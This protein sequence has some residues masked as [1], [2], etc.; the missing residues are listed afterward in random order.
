MFYEEYCEAKLTKLR[1]GCAGGGALKTFS[2][3]IF[4]HFM[5]VLV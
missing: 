4:Q 2:K 1:G 3:N 5:L